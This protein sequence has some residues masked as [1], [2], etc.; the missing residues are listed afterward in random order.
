LLLSELINNCVVHGVAAARDAWIDVTASIFPRSVWIEVC[1]GGPSFRY[2][3]RKPSPDAGSGRGL[4]L[5]QQ[6]SSRWGISG[7][8]PARVWFELARARLPSWF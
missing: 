3:P 5:V 8:G 2:E 6:L 4:Y 7:R 1:D